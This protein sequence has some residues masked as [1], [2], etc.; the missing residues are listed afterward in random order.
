MIVGW[1]SGG[2]RDTRF[3]LLNRPKKTRLSVLVPPGPPSRLIPSDSPNATRAR[4]T[5]APV[6]RQTPACATGSGV[7]DYIAAF[8]DSAEASEGDRVDYLLVSSDS[9][10]ESLD[11]PEE[12]DGSL[13]HKE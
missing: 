13:R 2:P 12:L 11:P 8:A 5:R 9:V 10:E 6:S 3:R 7:I 4:W 1:V